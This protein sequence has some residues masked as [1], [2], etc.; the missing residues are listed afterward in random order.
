MM[1]YF[2]YIGGQNERIYNNTLLN[3]IKIH[4]IFFAAIP[5]PEF[6]KVFE[7]INNKE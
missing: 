5:L 4:Q 6:N 7:P 3:H 1:S 2:N